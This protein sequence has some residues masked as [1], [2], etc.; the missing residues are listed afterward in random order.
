MKKTS[1]FSVFCA[2]LGLVGCGSSSVKTSS[3]YC[4]YENSE[5]SSEFTRGWGFT[6][7]FK[8]ESSDG[9]SHTVDIEWE[10]TDKSGKNV[11]GTGEE[12]GIRINPEK[13]LLVADR[14]APDDG[15]DINSDSFKE[16]AEEGFEC[17]LTS[18]KV[19]D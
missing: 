4:V 6:G 18:V 12:T 19:T 17:R 7:A 13:G 2:S 8:I 3:E 14:A 1:I 16:R 5:A 11:Y 9:K 15:V 10:V